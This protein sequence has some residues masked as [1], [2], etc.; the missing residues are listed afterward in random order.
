[1]KERGEEAR[2]SAREGRELDV[3]DGQESGKKMES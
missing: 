3:G 2:L 1:M